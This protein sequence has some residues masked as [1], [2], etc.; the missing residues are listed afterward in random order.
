MVKTRQPFD[1]LLFLKWDESIK[2]VIDSGIIT[3]D[4]SW[5]I[6]NHTLPV[7]LGCVKT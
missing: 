5:V 6:T 4:Y 1:P 7:P 3:A 2:L